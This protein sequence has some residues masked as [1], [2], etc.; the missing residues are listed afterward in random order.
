MSKLSTLELERLYLEI[1]EELGD[2]FTDTTLDKII[3]SKCQLESSRIEVTK[4]ITERLCQEGY[5]CIQIPRLS[6]VIVYSK[7]R[8]CKCSIENIE[9]E[10]IS[11]LYLDYEELQW[12]YASADPEHLIGVFCHECQS[13]VNSE[14][15]EVLLDEDASKILFSSDINEITRALFSSFPIY[16]DA[17]KTALKRQEIKTKKIPKTTHA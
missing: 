17:A 1:I 4:H 15:E 10:Q 11:I 12:E 3:A 13:Y 8:K 14:V 16:R 9:P 6:S 5:I 2:S 7:E